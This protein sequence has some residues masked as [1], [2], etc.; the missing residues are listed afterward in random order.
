MAKLLSDIQYDYHRLKPMP[1]TAMGNIN[2]A[3]KHLKTTFTGSTKGTKKSKLRASNGADSTS[4]FNTP[5]RGVSVTPP[6]HHDAAPELNARSS[7]R[8]ACYSRKSASPSVHASTEVAARLDTAHVNLS[9]TN[10]G[11]KKLTIREILSMRRTDQFTLVLPPINSKVVADAR[12]ARDDVIRA[13]DSIIIACSPPGLDADGILSFMNRE[14]AEQT[15]SQEGKEVVEYNVRIRSYAER[16]KLHEEELTKPQLEYMIGPGGNG[17][18][19]E[20]LGHGHAV[21]ALLKFRQLPYIEAY[22]PRMPDDPF[23][24]PSYEFSQSQS[25][26][27]ILDEL[28]THLQTRKGDPVAYVQILMNYYKKL[29]QK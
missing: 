21:T 13:F 22:V 4:Q 2:T 7:S 26:E 16:D 12:D 18:L 8:I 3:A 24:D 29:Y 19:L 28:K 23:L 10:H 20:L 25:D 5:R 11:T 9:S 27:S 1:V 17:I 15:I 14:R 6:A